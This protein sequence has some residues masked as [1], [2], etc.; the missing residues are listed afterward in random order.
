[1]DAAV[2]QSPE[3]TDTPLTLE[4]PRGVLEPSAPSAGAAAA[5]AAVRVVSDAQLRALL[6]PVQERWLCSRWA[7]RVVV[8][9]LTC[10]STAACVKQTRQ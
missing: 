10:S 4:A 9:I 6:L 7:V 5:L 1:M 8:F 2:G 3:R